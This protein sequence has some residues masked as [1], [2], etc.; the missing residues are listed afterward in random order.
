[1][2]INCIFFKIRGYFEISVLELTYVD[3]QTWFEQSVSL[4]YIKILFLLLL[5]GVVGSGD[6]SGW[7]SMPGRPTMLDNSRVRAYC[8]CNMG[9][10]ITCDFTSFSTI[11]Q[12][13][14]NDRWMIMKGCV[15]WTPFMIENIFALSGART[16]YC[17]ISKP[18]LNPLRYRGSLACS[19]CNWSLFGFFSRLSF[20]FFF[21]CL[22]WRRSDIN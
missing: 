10:W 22:S 15:Q 16:Q 14:Q 21:L 8:A 3:G 11:F 1:M 20:L 5:E 4:K 17:Y 12:S 13:Y 6:G 2:C 19:R 7:L 18:A 9:E